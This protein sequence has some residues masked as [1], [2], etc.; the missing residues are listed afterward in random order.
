MAPKIAIF[1]G[2]GV[3]RSSAR[4]CACLMRMWAGP[5]AEVQPIYSEQLCN[6]D[7]E[8]T[9]S[10]LVFPGGRT[11]FWT[12]GSEG[13]R[14]VGRWVKTQQGRY[15][16]ICAGAYFACDEVLF[17]QQAAPAI[18]PTHNVSLFGGIAEGPLFPVD[19]ECEVF[20]DA[21]GRSLEVQ[22][23]RGG[24]W[25]TSALHYQGGPVFRPADGQWP[26]QVQVLGKAVLPGS[27]VVLLK[28]C[29]P[30]GGVALLSS[31]HIENG[32]QERG[33][34]LNPEVGSILD[35]LL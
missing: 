12:L 27:P 19:H 31:A 17:R 21:G 8:E 11:R 33:N 23:E 6:T 5:D 20:S 13:E 2:P 14:R 24:Q 25:I 22:L 28:V 30:G 3:S 15:L 4:Q 10:I 26:K 34:A 1:N 32:V 7:W 9:L 18:T 16:G 35:N 29:Y